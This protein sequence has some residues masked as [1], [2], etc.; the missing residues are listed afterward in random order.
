MSDAANENA[1]PGDEAGRALGT[2]NSGAKTMGADFGVNDAEARRVRKPSF[3]EASLR[4]FLDAGLTLIPLHHW[5]ALDRRGRQVGKAPSDGAWQARRY[6]AKSVLSDAVRN[7][8]NLGVRLT[9]DL[10]VVD[11]DPRNYRDG[12]DSFAKLAADFGIALDDYPHVRTG[13]GGLHVY[14]HKPHDAAVLDSLDAYPGVEFKSGGR[15]VVAPGSIHPGGGEYVGVNLELLVLEPTAPA[16][17]VERIE[18]ASC[19][20]RR[21]VA[22]QAS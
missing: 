18:A 15:Q 6:N 16:P 12:V 5:N 3:D 19:A 13:G 4:P 1:R 21:S 10:L 8:H 20:P 9:P 2:T 22:T 14:M 11:V 17:L 7:G